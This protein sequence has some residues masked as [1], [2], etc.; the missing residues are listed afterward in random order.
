MGAK[1]DSGFPTEFELSL[2]E[3][4]V[5]SRVQAV[6]CD[7]ASRVAEKLLDSA[8]RPQMTV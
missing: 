7:A 6:G 5:H 4:Y 1:Q 8:G 2:W 3:R